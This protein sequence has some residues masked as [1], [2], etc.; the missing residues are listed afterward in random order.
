M[1]TEGSAL[2][3]L[4]TEV[5]GGH[6]REAVELSVSKYAPSFGDRVDVHAPAGII[7]YEVV[8]IK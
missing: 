4:Y 1:A 2:G 5:I 7:Q 8:E 6:S 3:D